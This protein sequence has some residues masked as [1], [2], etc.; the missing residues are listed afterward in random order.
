[1]NNDKSGW[2]PLQESINLSGINEKETK[3]L[4]LKLPI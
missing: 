4:N 1:M 3:I 2:K